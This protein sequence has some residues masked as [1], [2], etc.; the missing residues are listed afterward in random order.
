METRCPFGFMSVFLFLVPP[1]QD[2]SRTWAP[3]EHTRCAH[4]QA[5]DVRSWPKQD[6]LIS[7]IT[8]VLVFSATID[9]RHYFVEV[10]LPIDFVCL[11]YPIT[12]VLERFNI[13]CLVQLVPASGGVVIFARTNPVVIWIVR[14]HSFLEGPFNSTLRS[15]FECAMSTKE[16]IN[17]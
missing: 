7:V 17:G 14:Y 8:G 11:I 4:R 15:P 13:F 16:S 1:P 6:A 3:E 9:V 12:D 5:Q 2:A 10:L